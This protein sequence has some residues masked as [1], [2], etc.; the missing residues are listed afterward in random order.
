MKWNCFSYIRKGVDRYVANTFDSHL[1]INAHQKRIQPFLGAYLAGVPVLAMPRFGANQQRCSSAQ[2]SI[3]QLIENDKNSPGDHSPLPNIKLAVI[4]LWEL[5]RHHLQPIRYVLCIYTKCA[6]THEAQ[7]A[8]ILSINRKHISFKS[9]EK[10]YLYSYNPF[11]IC[12]I[13]RAKN[14]SFIYLDNTHFHFLLLSG[15]IM[16]P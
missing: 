8:F 10:A 15:D 6:G 4:S 11:H 7:Q 3:T 1:S 13:Q 9:N 12:K 16:F 2:Y 5:R 14:L